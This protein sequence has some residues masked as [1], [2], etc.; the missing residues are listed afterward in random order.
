MVR[1]GGGVCGDACCDVCCWAGAWV[2]AETVAWLRT[3]ATIRG[4]Q[5]L[6]T[7]AAAFAEMP[8]S[9][10][11]EL[12]IGIICGLLRDNDLHPLPVVKMSERMLPR[13][14]NTRQLGPGSERNTPRGC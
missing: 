13:G 14:A 6:Q 12:S 3:S 11:L 4:R 10:E 8:S 5:R 9:Q 7:R 2:C 1:A